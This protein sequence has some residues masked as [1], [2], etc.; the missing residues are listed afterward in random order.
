MLIIVISILLGKSRTAARMQAPRA[1]PGQGGRMGS[2]DG[3]PGL[4]GM[5][6]R[7]GGGATRQAC[8]GTAAIEVSP[9][10]RDFG[11][12]TAAAVA[13]QAATG[14]QLWRRTLSGND[15][16]GI[17]MTPGYNDGTVYVSTVP[18]NRAVGEYLGYG[19]A[20]L[21]ALNART[22]APEW[23]WDEVHNLWGNA[24]INSGGG[25]WDPPSFDSQGNL[26]I[27]V[28]NPGPMAQTGWPHGYPWGTSRPGYARELVALFGRATRGGPERS[29]G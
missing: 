11:G 2:D 10:T 12:R 26:Y 22:G 19:E 1:G 25:Q 24:G 18:V 15:H 9:L 8:A 13:L 3:A 6:R 17:D 16:E 29:E 7:H 21:W 23:S 28:A 14:R 4:T 20:T 27:G 5:G